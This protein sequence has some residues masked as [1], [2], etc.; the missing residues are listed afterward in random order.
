[1]TR[2]EQRK[3]MKLVDVIYGLNVGLIMEGIFHEEQYQQVKRI[4]EDLTKIALND[5]DPD[6]PPADV[7]HFVKGWKER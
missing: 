1:M 3:L 7:A 2:T 4:A 5:G 6:R